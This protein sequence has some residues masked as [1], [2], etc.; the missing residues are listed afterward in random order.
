MFLDIRE[1]L[2]TCLNHSC[3]L[4]KVIILCDNLL[5]VWQCHLIEFVKIKLL[6]ILSVHP[7]KLCEVKYSR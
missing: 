7:F 1:Y 6:Y 5:N 3:Y 4:L 2:N